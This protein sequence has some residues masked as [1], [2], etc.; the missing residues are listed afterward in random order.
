[1]RFVCISDT[2]NRHKSIKVPD[3]D[4][5]ICT[6]DFTLRGT[7]QELK[8]FDKWLGTLPHKHK[9][10]VAGNHDLILD[11]EGY[12]KIWSKWHKTKI[13]EDGRKLLTNCVYLQ[14]R[15]IKIEGIKIY[16]SPYQ[17]E[18][19]SMAF[20]RNENELRTIWKQIPPETNIL[21]THG[22]AYGYGDRTI[23][24][25]RVGCKELAKAIDQIRPQYHVFGHIH[26]SY[27]VTRGRISGTTHINT[28]CCKLFYQPLQQPIVFDFPKDLQTKT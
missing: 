15:L 11:G 8:N 22:P 27:G 5:L 9:I 23:F 10:V 28:A 1:V 7:V 26:E 19:R 16:G 4:V 25:K 3:G 24:G 13:E 6:G 14:D 2:H 18:F 21:L 20:N 12:E 17:P